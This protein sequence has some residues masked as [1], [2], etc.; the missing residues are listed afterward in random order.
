MNEIAIYPSLKNKVVL[1]TGGA[2]GIGESIVE[3]F[4][5][6]ESKVAFLDIDE[7][8]AEAFIDEFAIKP[9]AVN[10]NFSR[11]QILKLL[12]QMPNGKAGPDMLPG[13]ALKAL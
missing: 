10:F 3:Q 12:C 11:E 5:K 7:K 13:A 1:I 4:I 6:Q 2:Q 9:L 8:A